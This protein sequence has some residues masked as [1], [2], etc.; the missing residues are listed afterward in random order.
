MNNTTDSTL[1]R[2]GTGPYT[3]G[4]NLGNANTFTANQTAPKWITTGG[5]ASQFVKGDGTLDSNTYLTGTTGLLATGATTGATSQSQVFTNGITNSL[6]TKG[7]ILFAGTSGVESQNNAQLFWD[8]T[9]NR[10][11]VGTST[12]SQLLTVGNNNQ[13]TVDSSGNTSANGN[14]FLNP[15][16]STTAAPRTFGFSPSFNVGQAARLQFGDTN[17]VIQVAFADRMQASAYWGIELRGNQEASAPAFAGGSSS[18]ASVSIFGTTGNSANILNLNNNAGTALDV[19]DKSGNFGIG[20]TTPSRLLD[21][22]GDQTTNLFTDGT[23]ENLIRVHESTFADSAIGS[24]YF[25]QNGSGQTVIVNT[26]PDSG[27]GIAFFTNSNSTPNTTPRMLINSLGYV[28]IGTTTPANKLDLWGNLNVGTSST[29]LLFANTATGMIGIGTSTSVARLAIV[30]TST[31]DIFNLFDSTGAEKMTM[32]SSGYVGIGTITPGEK[33]EVAGAIKVTGTASTNTANS[34]V[35][36]FLSGS[37]RF[38]SF[39]PDSSTKGAFTIGQITSAGSGYTVPFYISPLSNIGIGTTNPQK[40]LNTFES[41]VTDSST[42]HTGLQINADFGT[43]PSSQSNAGGRWGITFNGAT[44]GTVSN[45]KLAGIYAVSEDNLGFNRKVGLSFMTTHGQDTNY[46]ESMRIADGGNVGIGT[47]TPA[48]TLDVNGTFAARSTSS[49]VFGNGLTG[50]IKLGDGTF[51]KTNGSSYQFDS[52]INLVSAN[53]DQGFSFNGPSNST[54]YGDSSA[55]LYF[56]T[57]GNNKRMTI[58]AT[59]NVGIGTTA[60]SANLSIVGTSGSAQNLLSVASSSGQVLSLSNAGVLTTYSNSSG[61]G[62]YILQG[63][64][65]N[66][67]A[68]FLVGGTEQ[69]MQ[70]GAVNSGVTVGTFGV[71]AN[72][73][74]LG[75]A[76]ETYSSGNLAMLGTNGT[77]L[78]T[79]LNNGNFGIGTA[80]PNLKLELTGAIYVSTST[81]SLLNGSVAS[82]QN[83]TLVGNAAYWGIRDSISHN[84]MLDVYG[85]G[86]PATALSIL[87]ANGNVGIGTSTPAN[88]LDIWG[89]LNVATGTTPAFFVNTAAG[90]VGVGT[91]TTAASGKL[92]VDGAGIFRPQSVTSSADTAPDALM[93]WDFQAHNNT[94][95]GS[96]YVRNTNGQQRAVFGYNPSNATFTLGAQSN[97]LQY[98]SLNAGGSGNNGAIT[99]NSYYNGGQEIMRLI[100]SANGGNVGIGTSTPANKLDIWGNLNVSTSSTPLLFANTGNS[101]IGIGTASPFDQLSNT[102]SNIQDAVSSGVTGNS[103]IAWNANAIGYAEGLNQSNSG[104]NGLLVKIL[105]TATANRIL[106]LNSNGVDRLV[107]QGNGYLGIGT[108]TPNGLLTIYGGDRGSS[109]NLISANN[110]TLDLNNISA[111]GHDYQIFS[112]PV[113]AGIGAGGFAFYDNTAGRYAFTILA[114]GRMGVNLSTSTLSSM[115]NVLGSDS[116]SANSSLNIMNSGY[117]SL[118]FVRNDGNV[119]IGTTSP[120]QLLTVGNNNQ[121]TVN[122]TSGRVT[123]AEHFMGTGVDANYYQDYNDTKGYWFTGAAGINWQN[124]NRVTSNVNVQ[125]QGIAGQTADIFQVASSSGATIFNITNQG[126]A[127]AAGLTVSHNT[128][129]NTYDQFVNANTAYNQ[130]IRLTA[131]NDWYIISAG[132]LGTTGQLSFLNNTAGV[133]PMYFLNDGSTWAQQFNQANSYT[134]LAGGT[135]NGATFHPVINNS[136]TDNLGGLRGATYQVEKQGAG[137]LGATVGLQGAMFAILNNGAGTVTG[138]AGFNSAIQNIGSG[139]ITNAYGAYFS[140]PTA[141]LT[142]PITNSYGLYIDNQGGTGVTNTYGIYQKTST[143]QNYFAGKIGIG[144]TTPASVLDVNG[145]IRFETINNCASGIQSSAAGVLSCYSSDER[146]KQNIITL[147]TSSGLDLIDQLNPVTFSY[148]DPNQAG[149]VQYGFIAQDVQGILPGL[150][151]TSSYITPWTPDGTLTLNYQ[152]LIAPLVEAVKELGNKVKSIMAWFGGDGSKMTI[153]GD[154]CVDNVCI[155]KEQFKAMLQNAGTASQTTQ[156]VTPTPTPTSTPTPEPTPVATSTPDVVPDSTPASTSTVAPPEIPPT[157]PA[158]TSS[159]VTSTQ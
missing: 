115:F 8:S 66:Q 124:I 41:G 60:P 64:N 122:G 79:M 50:S 119:G 36:D 101:K 52:G 152:G 82:N 24:A 100:P 118:F 128:A 89:N 109:L 92:E 117:S 76:F 150:V 9:N 47:T 136:V 43:S 75:S 26:R 71:G 68:L 46:S 63:T 61:S 106:D 29:P 17:S 54:I 2:S 134:T 44:P 108:S 104:G 129:A 31:N 12:P 135:K 146:I 85:G 149:G 6:N 15:A 132:T 145:S 103:S 96:I 95:G 19:V 83:F 40:V 78:S 58:D 137:N 7:S 67:A 102:S 39:G 65:G 107:F 62:K 139:T 13:F 153:Q 56:T 142:S 73:T 25:G 133:T 10:L 121:F 126:S 48:T 21:V 116:T 98:L 151:A 130:G 28:G 87:Q 99:F 114:N 127:T 105:G 90:N 74:T 22:N 51:S 86:T 14:L 84:F 141:S 33:L 32:L 70:F 77:V 45:N 110:P 18:D 144:T 16:G 80:S 38:V 49:A 1:T 69:R 155:T 11:G 35:Y 138:A 123:S 93:I 97:N 37:A 53:Y 30:G 94:N 4:L 148:K 55:K 120:S 156:T 42:I 3:L 72:N 158:D 20:T 143:D 113:S 157:P 91:S 154:V 147:A 88:K 57:G 81:N 59:G 111:G 159:D 5:T 27:D 34:G 23:R 131:S 125:L 112:T 140:T